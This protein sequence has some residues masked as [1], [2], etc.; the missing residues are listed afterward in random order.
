MEKQITSLLLTNNSDN[1]LKQRVKEL[2]DKVKRLET[3]A[4]TEGN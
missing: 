2:N 4:R 3:N 1:G